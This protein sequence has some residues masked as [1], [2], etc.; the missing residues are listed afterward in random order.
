MAL[1]QTFM[2][3]ENRESFE[4]LSVTISTAL[5]EVL[6][7]AF[8]NG[9]KEEIRADLRLQRYATLTEMIKNAQNIEERNGVVERVREMKWVNSI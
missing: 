2:V 3:A 7:G 4:A 9:L 5:K 8:K 6:T 1:Q